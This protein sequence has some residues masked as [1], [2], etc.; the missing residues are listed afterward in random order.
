[1][2]WVVGCE[3]GAVCSQSWFSVFSAGLL[4]A[5]ANTSS[6]NAPNDQLVHNASRHP[7]RQYTT[8]NSA[9]EWCRVCASRHSNSLGL[10][11]FSFLNFDFIFLTKT[12]FFSRANNALPPFSRKFAAGFGISIPLNTKIKTRNQNPLG[13]TGRRFVAPFRTRLIVH[14]KARTTCLLNS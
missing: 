9:G 13:V 10:H 2:Q 1:M 12:L 4:Y 8:I 11:K 3:G 6:A 14:G 5:D 7:H